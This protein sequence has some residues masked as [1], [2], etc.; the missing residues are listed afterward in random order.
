MSFLGP[1]GEVFQ[2]VAA[3]QQGQAQKSAY[4]QQA[5]QAVTQAKAQ[6]QMTVD[7]AAEQKQQDD[8]AAENTE[9]AAKQDQAN[10]LAD[11][12]RTVGTIRATVAGRSLSLASPS[13]GALVDAATGYTQRDIAI[14]NF[15]SRQD[16]A[17]YR[18]AGTTTV[19]QGNRAALYGLTA[20]SQ[21][22][23]NLRTSGSMA[24]AAGYVSGASSFLKAASDANS[25]YGAKK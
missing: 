14:A 4:N 11:L 21:Q 12:S 20:G 8:I 22:A 23:A 25:L 19:R 15:N 10:R 1:V 24:A 2:G 18:L 7:Q 6:A 17:N 5:D 3:I 13:A 16:A 9:L